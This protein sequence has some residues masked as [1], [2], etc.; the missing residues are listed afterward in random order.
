MIYSILIVCWCFQ[1]VFEAVPGVY[2]GVFQGVYQGVF[3][4]VSGASLSHTCLHE[5][6]TINI[7]TKATG[8]GLRA[9]SFGVWLFKRCSALFRVECM[10]VSG[11]AR[12]NSVQLMPERLIA[13][14]QTAEGTIKI[15]PRRKKKTTTNNLQ[16]WSSGMKIKRPGIVNGKSRVNGTICGP[17]LCW[18]LLPACKN[19]A[20]RIPQEH[21]K[22]CSVTCVLKAIKHSMCTF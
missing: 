3:Q 7:C 22:R 8:V 4:G 10:C 20:T 12:L 13:D 14:F 16:V 1:N 21:V 11:Y 9:E 2:Q 6:A 15:I 17:A 18:F 5:R 19:I